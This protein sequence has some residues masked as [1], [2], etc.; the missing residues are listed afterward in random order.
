MATAA[1]HHEREKHFM[2][3]AAK[4]RKMA[5]EAG[6]KKSE[7]PKAEM[8]REDRKEDAKRKRA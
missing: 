3:E 7:R 5:K 6:K 4:H 2:A 8:R 1:H